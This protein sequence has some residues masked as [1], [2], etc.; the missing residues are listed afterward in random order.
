MSG[1]PVGPGIGLGVQGRLC[2]L[3]PLTTG[4][5]PTDIQ[6]LAGLPFSQLCSSHK[7]PIWGGDK[8]P[9]EAFRRILYRQRG[10]VLDLCRKPMTLG[11]V[12]EASPFY[13]NRFP[14]RRIQRMFETHL[15]AKNLQLLAEDGQVIFSRGTYQMTHPASVDN[16]LG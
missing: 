2:H 10:L 3:H 16:V 6:S 7:P 11:Q 5:S 8:A 9:L 13:Q 12:V 15:V 1:N 14:D 4:L